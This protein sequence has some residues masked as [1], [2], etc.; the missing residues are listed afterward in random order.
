M[1]MRNRVVVTIVAIASGCSLEVEEV[2][3]DAGA[4]AGIDAGDAGSGTDRVTPQGLFALGPVDG[5]RMTSRARPAAPFKAIDG[6]DEVAESLAATGSS[7][8]VEETARFSI[9][10]WTGNVANTVL[11]AISRDGS[12]LVHAVGFGGNEHFCQPGG[13]EARFIRLSDAT[14]LGS[15]RVHS[16]HCE[17]DGEWQEVLTPSRRR[18]LAREVD[19]LN[20]RLAEGGFRSL[21]ELEPSG[22][23]VA[24]LTGVRLEWAGPGLQIVS[25]APNR[26]I[27]MVSDGAAVAAWSWRPPRLRFSCTISL[28]SP[29]DIVWTDPWILAGHADPSGVAILEVGVN[30]GSCLCDPDSAFWLIRPGRRPRKLL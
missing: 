12:V 19:R 9:D 30:Y 5:H 15:L 27:S 14:H 26:S 28:A 3:P 22:T 20:R 1:S 21:A 7:V 16:I 24:E 8:G 4:D 2:S 29:D 10:P 11:P 25:D 17:G 13:F 18:A 23:P 6:A